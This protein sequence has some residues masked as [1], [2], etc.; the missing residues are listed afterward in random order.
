MHLI[1]LSPHFSQRMICHTPDNILHICWFTCYVL[2]LMLLIESPPISPPMCEHGLLLLLRSAVRL[3]SGDYG[4]WLNMLGVTS[5]ISGIVVGIRW[6]REIYLT[7]S[8]VEIQSLS[9]QNKMACVDHMMPRSHY[10]PLGRTDKIRKNYIA[11]HVDL[12][13]L[14][15]GRS[16]ANPTGF[17]TGFSF[18]IYFY[19]LFP[20]FIWLSKRRFKIMIFLLPC[21]M[22]SRLD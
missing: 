11:L 15:V 21:W 17:H 18:W 8:L 22:S 2:A 4:H 14:Q 10:K 20:V 16:T 12:A 3:P 6:F 7:S 9:V 13:W 1:K 19:S 5:V